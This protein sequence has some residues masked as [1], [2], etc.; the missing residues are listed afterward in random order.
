MTELPDH[1]AIMVVDTKGFS[2]HNDVQQEEL[3][4]QLY[5]ALEDAFHR[6]GLSDVWDARLFPDSTGDGYMIGFPPRHLPRVIDSYFDALQQELTSKL[7]RLRAGGM[8]LRMRLSLE[9]GPADHQTDDRFG[10]PVGNTM[11]GTHRLVDSDP[12]RDLLDRSDPDVTLLA[13]VLSERV[14][15]DVVRGGHTQRHGP[16]EFVEVT[17]TMAKKGFA[18]PA[19]LYV[20]V[21]SGD[22]L[23]HGLGGARPADRPKPVG[24]T[25][26]KP[27]RGV[28]AS[29]RGIAAGGNIGNIDQSRQ[30]TTVHGDQFNAHDISIRGERRQ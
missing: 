2:R 18:E 1:V 19:F 4:Q 29:S 13:V 10:S 28:R 27:S 20:P 26:P 3:Q 24:K 12:V 15:K 21:I 11:I 14:M 22:L 17:V 23:R 6:C 7:R 16:S 9:Y 5:Q 30:E 25:V 8:S